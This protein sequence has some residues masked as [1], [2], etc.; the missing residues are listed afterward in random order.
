[1]VRP[2]Q[3]DVDFDVR[4]TMAKHLQKVE[5]RLKTFMEAVTEDTAQCEA[6]KSLVAQMVWDGSGRAFEQITNLVLGKKEE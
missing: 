1:M 4:Q 3:A 2:S 5:G 6:R